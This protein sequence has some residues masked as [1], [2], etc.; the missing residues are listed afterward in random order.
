MAQFPFATIGADKAAYGLA[1]YTLFVLLEA[2]LGTAGCL[3]AEALIMC[4]V[5]WQSRRSPAKEEPLV[6]SPAD[7]AEAPQQEPAGE[8]ASKGSRRHGE[9][10][11]PKSGPAATLAP[12]AGS[13]AAA[14]AQR[15]KRSEAGTGASGAVPASPS[16]PAAPTLGAASAGSWAAQQRKRREEAGGDTRDAE[17]ARSVKSILNKLTLEKFDVLYAKLIALGIRTPAQAEILVGEIVE[18]AQAQHHFVK[19]YSELCARL[20][21]ELAALSGCNFKQVLLDKCQRSFECALKPTTEAVTHSDEVGEEQAKH[22]ERMLGN[23]KLTG[24]LL[25]RHML[26]SRVLIACA[27]EL[28][29]S[30]PS[31]DR[32][33][34]LAVLLEVTGPA[35]DCPSWTQH[36]TLD[37]VF[38]KVCGLSQDPSVPSRVRCLLRDVIDLRA[39]GWVDSRA[40]SRVEKPKRLEEVHKEAA[41]DSP[42]LSR[43]RWGSEPHAEGAGTVVAQPPHARKESWRARQADRQDEPHA[44]GARAV[45]TQPPHA[46]K[47]SW[48][49]GQADLQE[50][51]HAEGGGAVMAQPPNARKES[52]RARQ[53]DRQEEW[54]AKQT[55]HGW[56]ASQGSKVWQAGHEGSWQWRAPAGPNWQR[57]RYCLDFA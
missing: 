36:E 46:R 41:E 51:P 22:K 2:P 42:F 57:L 8:R 52:W 54:R 53:A 34:C 23:I 44:E 49:A 37:A 29:E 3:V 32:L 11:S 25:T 19:M 45:T 31:A 35:F 43:P 40:A 38:A 30:P 14:A 33:E 7:Y 17:F 28:L 18:K 12:S 16:A 55:S 27:E 56:Q 9:Q 47:E 21:G 4:V 1:A 13:W 10:A 15:R 48:R 5:L 20:E 39:A 24:E 6:Q 26:S 50:E